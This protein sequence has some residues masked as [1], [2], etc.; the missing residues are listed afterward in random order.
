MRHE[1]VVNLATALVLQKEADYMNK[2]RRHADRLANKHSP[3][4]D[5]VLNEMIIEA[6]RLNYRNHVADEE[7]IQIYN[8][9]HKKK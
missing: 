6:K 7:E 1:R 5:D 4:A 9:E 3:K 2:A 8:L